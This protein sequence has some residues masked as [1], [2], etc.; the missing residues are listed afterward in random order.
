METKRTIV[1]IDGSNLYYGLLRDTVYKWLDLKAFAKK[2]LLPEYQVVAIKYF[3]SRVIDKTDGHLRA[4]RQ[5]RYIDAISSR[6]VQ[7]FEG[8]YR[9]RVERLE[10]VEPACKSCGLVGHPGH[11]R[12]TRMSEKLT[13]VSPFH[14]SLIITS[15]GS[16]GIPPIYHHIYN[17]GNL[18]IFI[19]YGI[20]QIVPAINKNGE[21]VPKKIVELKITMDE[22]IASGYELSTAFK[23]LKHY[24]EHPE[25]LELPPKE[26]VQDI[27]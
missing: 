4:E 2:L 27:Y 10:A 19:A 1:Y 13:D 26:V 18:P 15:M 25:L 12:G 9:V 5:A 17:F 14:G 24:L 8:Y 21:T 23:S 16:L 11:V 6:G 7:V 20:K 3:A 22:R